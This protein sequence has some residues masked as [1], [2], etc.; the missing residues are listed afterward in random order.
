M[1]RTARRRVADDPIGAARGAGLRYVVA[2][3]EGGI[4]RQRVGQGFTYRRD[5]KTVSDDKTLRRIRALAIPPAW[6]Q[7]WICSDPDGHVQATGRDVRGRKQYRYHPRWRA[8]RDETKF[9]RM[10]AFGK[11]LPHLRARVARDV[12]RPGLSRE[13]VLGTVVRLLETTLIRVGNDEYARQNHSFGLTTLQDRHVAI[14]G[15]EVRFHFRGKSGKEHSVAVHDPRIARIVKRCRDIPGYDLFQFVDESGRRQAVD[16]AGVNAYIRHTMKD[17]FTAKDF[18][19]WAG[20]VLAARALGSGAAPGSEAGTRKAIVAA[21]GAVAAQLGN[22]V[23]VCRKSYIHPAIFDC[24]RDGELPRRLGTVG[25]RSLHPGAAALHPDE[26]A[27]LSLLQGRLT[28]VSA[29]RAS[30]SR[31]A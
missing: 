17:D 28:G 29:A 14:T 21:I 27:V 9:H 12:A 6:R 11:A 16:S 22:T 8:E 30:G 25:P 20:T 10:L 19:T 26:K 18:R 4:L 13:K 23:A 1:P 15:A 2:G 7:V 3:G 5:G 24:Y 31:A